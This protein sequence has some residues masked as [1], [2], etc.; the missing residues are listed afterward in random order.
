VNG[1]NPAAQDVTEVSNIEQTAISTQI[2]PIASADMDIQKI[3]TDLRE[4]RDQIDAV[5][6][7]LKSIAQQ[8]APRR[9]RPPKWLTVKRI[10]AS[11][12]GTNG[13][14]N[15]ALHLPTPRKSASN[16]T[17]AATGQGSGD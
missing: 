7:A 1:R 8:Q 14:V 17:F 6:E 4:R 5:I 13:S 16:S 12:N 2:Y 15:G 9:G 11:K 3:L 10:H